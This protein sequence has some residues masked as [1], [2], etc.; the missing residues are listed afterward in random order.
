MES[1]KLFYNLAAIQPVS[2]TFEK[3]LYKKNN[4]TLYIKMVELANRITVDGSVANK[5]GKFNKNR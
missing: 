2:R 4:N 1:I 5:S 3:P